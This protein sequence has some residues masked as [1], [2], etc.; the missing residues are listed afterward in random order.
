M[1]VVIGNQT[2]N[3]Q[4]YEYA[5]LLPAPNIKSLPSTYEASTSGG[6]VVSLNGEK[7]GAYVGVLQ[8]VFRNQSGPS[9]ISTTYATRATVTYWTD[10]LV[11]FM[12]PSGQGNPSI[13][14]Y[15]PGAEN[16]TTVS[17][18]GL[19]YSAPSISFVFNHDSK[20]TTAGFEPPV[21]AM[22]Q[23]LTIT[24]NNF[25]PND[26][27][28]FNQ[29]YVVSAYNEPRLCAVVSWNHTVISCQP[30]LGT[31]RFN[32]IQVRVFKRDVSLAPSEDQYTTTSPSSDAFRFA[33]QPPQLQRMFLTA[34]NTSLTHGPTLGGAN[35][36][37]RGLS[38]GVKP[39][40]SS[41]YNVVLRVG[42]TPV[43][44]I[45]LDH[46]VLTFLTPAGMGTNLPVTLEID[47]QVSNVLMFSYDPPAILR[48]E[49]ISGVRTAANNGSHMFH[50]NALSS[51]I[52]I[53]GINF[54]V[55]PIAITFP[56]DNPLLPAEH[57][58][59]IN[60]LGQSIIE[61]KLQNFRVGYKGIQ[62]DISL[63]SVTMT[64]QEA[65]LVAECDVGFFG[66]YGSN[67]ICQPCPACV[68][69]LSATTSPP[70]V[71]S[72]GFAEP[73]AAPGYWRSVSLQALANSTQVQ[74]SFNFSACVPPVGCTGNNT[75]DVGYSSTAC[76][77]CIPKKFHRD[78]LTGLCVPCP[79]SAVLEL[80]LVFV[81][82]VI[83]AFGLYKLYQK[84]PSVAA[85]GIAVDYFQI[86][87]IFGALQMQWPGPV[88]TVFRT[89]SAS[90]SNADVTSPECSISVGY[91]PKWYFYQVLPVGLILLAVIGNFV[92]MI[93]KYIRHPSRRDEPGFLTK[94]SAG[95]YGF[96]LLLLNF[97]Y[98]S[99]T[100]RGF[101]ALDCTR[102]GFDL[103][104]A[105]D[106]TVSCSDQTYATLKLSAYI[107]IIVYGLGVPL[108]YA[109]IVFR[110]AGRMK[111]DQALRIRGL[112]GSRETNPFFEMQKRFKRL[113][114]KF[115]PEMYF[116]TLIS[117]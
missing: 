94:H 25:G 89:A 9:V 106:A 84:G 99:L 7:F 96:C 79:G 80:V 38:L 2:S 108:L 65:K 111:V 23:L 63:Q 102:V 41:T 68:S 115:R 37:I 92:L 40:S 18:A 67:S 54:E 110:A 107:S 95:L 91:V 114:F 10:A 43:T 5:S 14:M 12:L 90:A 116:W 42:D 44:S 1:Q 76:S 104:L 57:P 81:A 55:S 64:A 29:V 50:F 19:R 73:I 85:I 26:P 27:G 87:S 51:V 31:G 75:C 20:F 70:S 33:Y 62:L 17:F 113:Y 88:L 112:A 45:V 13:V 52:R 34:R 3:V 36:T 103:V 56:S 82:V 86:M 15:I 74:Q 117:A 49:E 32:T 30:P 69:C 8:L 78:L 77:V 28:D 83:V 93:W 4:P 22:P 98:I 105:V 71:C 109:L 59:T 16:R 72:G 66:I 39:A 48:F 47:R 100:K 97:M 11:N 101:E 46:S 21:D 58:S 60:L 24:G 61:I 6:G 35:V 53:H